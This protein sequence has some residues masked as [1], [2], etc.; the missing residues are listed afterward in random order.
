MNY[1]K[2]F[3]IDFDHN[4]SGIN[5]AWVPP[6]YR[7]IQVYHGGCD[8]YAVDN[9]NKEI[10][11]DTKKGKYYCDAARHLAE[12]PSSKKA[13]QRWRSEYRD[14]GINPYTD[15]VLSCCTSWDKR[16]TNLY[17]PPKIKAVWTFKSLIEDGEDRT[18]AARFLYSKNI[19]D[20]KSGI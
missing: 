3:I 14:T 20:Q 16:S 10:S 4:E 18:A 7:F 5:A 9:E 8:T 6:G 15:I 17:V 12:G 11:S 2:T 13:L 19:G 1:D